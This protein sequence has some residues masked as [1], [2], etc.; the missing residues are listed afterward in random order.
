VCEV[1][2]Y[3]STTSRTV[4]DLRIRLDSIGADLERLNRLIKMDIRLGNKK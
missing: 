4:A 1:L 3:K 2:N